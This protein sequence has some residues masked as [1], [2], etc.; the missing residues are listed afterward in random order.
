MQVAEDNTVA[1]RRAL[2]TFPSIISSHKSLLRS[3]H[4]FNSF[5]LS[6][7]TELW[8]QIKDKYRVT[9][10]DLATF[11]QKKKWIHP[12]HQVKVQGA[13]VKTHM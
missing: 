12:L 9:V 13:L 7:L 4:V 5:S 1:K 8:V 11:F 3:N 10:V 6:C 2:L